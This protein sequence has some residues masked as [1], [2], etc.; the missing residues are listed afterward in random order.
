MS[1]I[2][3]REEWLLAMTEELR[4]DFEAIG[5]PLP[6]N[7]RMSVGFTSKGARSKSIGQCWAAEASADS[8]HSIFISPV[9]DSQLRI[10][11]VLVHELVH[12]AA[13]AGAKHGPKFRKIA[14]A[15]GLTGKM[16]ATV[17]APRLVA[18]L[19]EIIDKV[20]D[21]PHAAL[22]SGLPVEKKQTTR[23]LKAC[24]PECGYTVRVA[25]K[26]VNE[27]GAP[28]CPAHGAMSVEGITT[29]ADAVPFEEAA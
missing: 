16:S 5:A 2:A 17:A 13:P 8:V 7:I 25:A 9:L 15:M 1:K 23:L 22:N 28:H 18:R 11:D 27:A 4:A 20:G 14:E 3:T 6:K 10:G 24:C 26:W 19:Q 12:A 21:M 29:D